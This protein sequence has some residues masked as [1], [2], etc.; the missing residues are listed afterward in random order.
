MSRQVQFS[1]AGAAA[2]AAVMF[3]AR[4]AGVFLVD[5]ALIVMAAVL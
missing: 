2:A 1:L 5:T 4:S 3:V